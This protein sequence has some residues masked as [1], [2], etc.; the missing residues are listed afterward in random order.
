MPRYFFHMAIGPAYI[1]DYE[2]TELANEAAAR[3]RAIEN[4]LAVWKAGA[5]RRQNPAECAV[6]VSGPAGELFRVPFVSAPGVLS[7]T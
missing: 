3:K 7:G 1:H 5:G 2:G 6:V 4:I